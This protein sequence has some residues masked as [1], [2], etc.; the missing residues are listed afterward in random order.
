MVLCVLVKPC[1]GIFELGTYKGITTLHLANNAAPKSSIIHTLDL[2]PEMIKR[3]Y[4]VGE[5]LEKHQ[6][7]RKIVQLYADSAIF[8]FKLYHDKLDFI[9][10]DG[11]H[12]Y[13]AVKRDTANLLPCLKKGV[14]IWDDFDL[15]HHRETAQGILEALEENK[16]ETIKAR[17][18]LLKG[19]KF[20][21][22]YR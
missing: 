20:L 13:A 14:F 4:R 9:F 15:V 8:D 22:M 19:T 12:S 11:D 16:N 10:I 7:V 21:I 3:N 18:Y 1:K 2:P 5:Y 17:F 6:A